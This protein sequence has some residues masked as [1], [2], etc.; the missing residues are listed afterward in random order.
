MLNIAAVRVPAQ[1]DTMIQSWDMA[2]KDLATSDYVVGQV[3]GAVQ[4]D[5]FLL[6]QRRAADG[7]AGDE[8]GRSRNFS[9]S[10]PRRPPSWWR[11]RRMGR[12][13]IQELRHDVAGLIEVNPE[14][15]KDRASAC[16]IAP[17]RVREYLPATSGHR[18][19]GGG[20]HRG[21]GG[22]S[23]RPQR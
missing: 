7:Y 8:G 2:F 3:W 4:A 19:L 22:V 1:F 12:L 18:A 21:S 14:G 17:G 13:I 16:H 9:D 5:R 23:E 6:D 10:G 15:G 20:F 11:T